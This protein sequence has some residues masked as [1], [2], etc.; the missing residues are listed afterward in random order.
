MLTCDKK[1]R[2]EAEGHSIEVRGSI[3]VIKQLVDKEIVHKSRGISL[4]KELKITNNRL[5][6]KEIDKLIRQWKT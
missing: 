3:W 4:L 6:V 1:L 5:P 2:K